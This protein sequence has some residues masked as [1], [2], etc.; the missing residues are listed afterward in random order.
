[1]DKNCSLAALVC[2]WHSKNPSPPDSAVLKLPLSVENVQPRA[3]LT[4]LSSTSW[5]PTFRSLDLV[6]ATLWL[7]GPRN[8]S[9]GQLA[10]QSLS[11]GALLDLL[12]VDCCTGTLLQWGNSRL[13]ASASP[14]Y[15][16]SVPWPVSL[17]RNNQD[18]DLDLSNLCCASEAAS[19]ASTSAST[20]P[21]NKD[22]AASCGLLRCS[23]VS[24]LD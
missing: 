16:F 17:S 7:Q 24:L 22:S 15:T 23:A 19:A 6:C 9:R 14:P 20:F 4:L 10:C 11:A 8:L 1:M 12:N 3:S 13:K 18:S 5:L 2:P 21:P